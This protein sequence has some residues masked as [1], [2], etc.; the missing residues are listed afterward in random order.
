MVQ[1]PVKMI[2]FSSLNFRQWQ[3]EISLDIFYNSESKILAFKAISTFKLC[4]SQRP[5]GFGILNLIQFSCLL[6]FDK[7]KK[8]S[9]LRL[10]FWLSE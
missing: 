9:G 6:R 1:S 3:V 2:G 10:E 4:L 8:S 5:S 7:R